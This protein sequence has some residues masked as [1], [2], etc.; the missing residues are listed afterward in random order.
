VSARAR[1]V[2]VPPS[3]TLRAHVR[4]GEVPGALGDVPADRRL[5]EACGAPLGE[6]QRPGARYHGGACRAAGS[7]A[8][9]RQAI[10]ERLETLESELTALRAE[11]MRLA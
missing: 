5:C 4:V 9:R 6:R 8:R 10:L 7:R 11:V 3:G 2:E 1:R